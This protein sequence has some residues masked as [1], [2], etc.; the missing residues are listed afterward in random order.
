MVLAAC[1]DDLL[2]PKSPAASPTRATRSVGDVSGGCAEIAAAHPGSPDGD[3]AVR[4][5]GGATFK[6]YCYNMASAPATYLT[7]GVSGPESGKNFGSWGGEYQHL[8]ENHVIE[9]YY[10]RLRF[11]PA[12]LQVDNN[13]ITF[14]ETIGGRAFGPGAYLYSFPYANAG[15]CL[16]SAP[17]GRANIDLNGTPFSLDE[18][19]VTEGWTPNGYV[20][21]E[22]NGWDETKAVTGKTADL[23][24]GG[25]CGGTN[26]VKQRGFT[27]FAFS[28]PA[29]SSPSAAM[30][31]S[32]PLQ[33]GSATSSFTS[34]ASHPNGVPFWTA[35]DLGDGTTGTGPMPASH[36]Y[37]ADNGTY[38]VTFTAY[39]G[40]TEPTTVTRVVVVENVAP[41]VSAIPGATIFAGETYGA[42]GTFSD[43]GT[44]THTGT[45]DYGDGAGALTLGAG[46]FAL[47]HTYATPGTYTVTVTI[48]DDDG[49][50]TTSSATVKV[51]SAADAAR[52]LMQLIASL[53]PEN[54]AHPLIVSLEQFVASLGRGSAASARGQLGAFDNKL[55]ADLDAG[56]ISAA[57]Y[58][59]LAEYSR[60]IRASMGE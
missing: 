39:D 17:L 7:L 11:D 45:V 4:G 26:P 57:T 60:R 59:T 29:L 54:Q 37:A 24:G 15:D 36:T 10:S 49:A 50:S 33:E 20:N 13:D 25:F 46:T 22:Y 55:R 8:W 34:S 38:T 53:M 43:P 5:M 14:S 51:L 31:A 41:A 9:T 40:A 23:V 19:F 16:G 12:T 32:S 56:K 28:G 18:L 3:Y 2:A 44:D 1:A 58:A 27:Q 48:M 47:S 35:W 30:T 21:G 42:T 6:V 52:G